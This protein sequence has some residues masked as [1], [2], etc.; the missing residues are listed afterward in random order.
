VPVRGKKAIVVE[1]GP[2]LT[3][4]G[5]TF[6]AAT[7]AAKRF[8]ARIIAAEKYAVG[9]IRTVYKNYPHLKNILPAMGYSKKQVS[10][11]EATINNAKCD[12]VIDG[13]PVNL[14]RLIKSNKPIVEVDYEIE[15]VGHPNFADI[16]GKFEKKYLHNKK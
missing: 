5:M 16:L 3:H 6:G 2:T 9:S 13:S 15:E 12:I 8:G 10:E 14:S 11:L 1:D 4:G 7:L